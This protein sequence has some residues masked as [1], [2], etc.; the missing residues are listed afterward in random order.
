MASFALGAELWDFAALL[1]KIWAKSRLTGGE[2]GRTLSERPFGAVD[3]AD[4]GGLGRGWRCKTMDVQRLRLYAPTSVSRFVSARMRGAARFLL[5]VMAGQVGTTGQENDTM[6]GYILAFCTLAAL[7]A[8]PA[9]ACSVASCQGPSTDW[10][11]P[12]QGE[13]IPANAPALAVSMRNTGG[14]ALPQVTL[15]GANA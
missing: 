2:F 4:V 7:F 12:S 13:T 10:A 6:R 9:E 8:A 1:G 15:T 14:P 5:L 3:F 11:A